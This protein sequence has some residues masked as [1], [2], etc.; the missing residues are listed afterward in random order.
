VDAAQTPVTQWFEAQEIESAHVMAVPQRGQIPA[1][2]PQSTADSPPFWLLSWQFAAAQVPL[3]Q[4]RLSQSA[5]ILQALS[6]MQAEQE[7]PQSTSVSVPSCLAL[8]H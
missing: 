3:W 5:A 6:R 8:K 4:F 7:P 2:S 1:T